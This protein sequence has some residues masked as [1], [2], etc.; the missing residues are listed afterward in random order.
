M[1]L[2]LDVGVL[3]IFKIRTKLAYKTVHLASHTRKAYKNVE[4]QVLYRGDVSPR[5]AF[6]MLT[7]FGQV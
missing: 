7:A 2:L 4:P 6:P 3:V 1:L 5:S